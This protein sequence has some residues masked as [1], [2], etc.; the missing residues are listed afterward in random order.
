MSQHVEGDLPRFFDIIAFGEIHNA[1]IIRIVEIPQGLFA[2][3][4]QPLF[5]LDRQ[6]FPRRAWT[7]SMC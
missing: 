6:G 1:A 5:V 4:Q 3:F 7:T 2:A